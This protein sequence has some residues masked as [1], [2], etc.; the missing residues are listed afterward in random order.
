[1]RLES[2][3]PLGYLPQ[4]TTNDF[5]ASL[6]L[7]PGPGGGRRAHRPRAACRALDIGRW[8]QRNFIYVA[9]FGAFT[10]SSYTASQA[11]K[12]ALGHFA[13][14]LEGMKDLNTL[15]P[16]QHPAHRRRGGAGRRVPLRRRVQLHLH[17]RA[18]EAGPGAGGAGRREIRDAAG[19]QPQD[20]RG[21]A[22]SGAGPAEPAVRQRGPGVP[23]CLL[24]PPGDGGG[25]ALVPGRGVRPQRCRW[26]RSPT[27]SGR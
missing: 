25:P 3:P 10:R 7:P 24:P 12:N 22:E 21:P 8:N 17:R 27:A 4:G 18:D 13:Y 15:R 6:Q 2:P 23:P 19:P 9:S 26:W 5:A 14:I 20:R 11:A 1:M 16:Y